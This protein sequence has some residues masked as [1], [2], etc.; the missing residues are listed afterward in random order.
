MAESKKGNSTHKIGPGYRAGLLLVLEAAEPRKNGGAVWRCRCDCGKETLV[1]SRQ[2][3]NGHSKSCGCLLHPPLKDYVGQRFGKL[4]VIGYSGK[5]AGMHRWRCRCDCGRETVVGQTL[6]QSGKTKSCGCIQA[7]SYLQ[8]LKLY[9]GT[10][11]TVLESLSRKPSKA[12]TS[13]YT[14]VYQDKRTGKWNAQIRL[15]GKAYYLGSYTNIEDAVKAR[16]RGEEMHRQ[17]IADYY[18]ALEKDED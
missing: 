15:K 2:L 12:N 4:T 7:S 6:L 16:R 18:E 14:G 11:V 17:C 13:G 5:R 8:N 3:L 9:E 10:S 1:P